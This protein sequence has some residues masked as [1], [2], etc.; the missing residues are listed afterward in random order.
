MI[1]SRTLCPLLI[2]EAKS[3]SSLQLRRK[4]GKAKRCCEERIFSLHASSL[5]SLQL[6]HWENIETHLKFSAGFS[7][8]A[9]AGYPVPS[10]FPRCL[11]NPH[12]FPRAEATVV[13]LNTQQQLLDDYQTHLYPRQGRWLWTPAWGPQPGIFPFPHSTGK[14]PELN[15]AQQRRL[16]V[17]PCCAMGQPAPR[18]WEHRTATGFC[19][20]SLPG[21]HNSEKVPVA[22]LIL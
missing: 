6:T 19:N 5:N 13:L 22:W 16:Q 2:K 10:S 1:I 14:C 9:Q 15:S 7:T 18:R 12:G 21:E 20:A 17:H 3:R 11:E 4:K 8:E